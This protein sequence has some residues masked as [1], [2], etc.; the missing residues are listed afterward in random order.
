MLAKKF[1][2][3]R[4]TSE[5]MMGP[6]MAIGVMMMNSIGV[7]GRIVRISCGLHYGPTCCIRSIGA[8]ATTDLG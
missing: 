4:S 8:D 7:E 6:A 5:T 3:P 2:P 1:N